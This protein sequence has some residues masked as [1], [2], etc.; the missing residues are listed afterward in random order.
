MSDLSLYPKHCRNLPRVGSYIYVPP[1]HTGPTRLFGGRAKVLSVERLQP[2]SSSK[3][4]IEEHPGHLYTWDELRHKQ[5]TLWQEFNATFAKIPT[6]EE[7]ADHDLARARA[8]EAKRL[9]AHAKADAERRR[10]EPIRLKCL[11]GG[12]LET[13]VNNS[14]H[15]A[16]NWVAI[17]TLNPTLPGGIDR[18][19][20]HRGSG[21]VP[22]I[23]PEQLSVFDVVEF[24][25]DYVRG[26]GTRDPVR[27]Y[28]V[29]LAVTQ[30]SII[31]Q[32][33]KTALAAFELSS[34]RKNPEDEILLNKVAAV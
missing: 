27:W 3:I 31:L 2:V 12:L 14:H 25:A 24:G 22:Y 33:C 1:T 21:P 18:F 5:V 7:V 30:T 29:V 19:W 9:E 28:G 32:P 11:N 34:E 13:P 23:V 16:R 4:V 8:E 10:W 20:F 26:S 15:R 17:V 6:L